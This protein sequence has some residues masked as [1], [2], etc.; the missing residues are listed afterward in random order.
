MVDTQSATAEI[1][2]GK[3]K[4][5]R[6]T[7]WANAQRDGHPAEYRWRLLF[8]CEDIARQS[9]MHLLH[10]VVIKMS[11]RWYNISM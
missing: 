1:R 4:K 3:R 9:C 10:T 6:T 8:S 11:L 7:I 5:E 2:R